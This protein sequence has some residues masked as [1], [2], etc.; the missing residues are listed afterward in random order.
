MAQKQRINQV[1]SGI[2]LLMIGVLAL[3]FTLFLALTPPQGGTAVSP[4]L[5]KYHYYSL[6]LES[7]IANAL[8]WLLVPIPALISLKGGIWRLRRALEIRQ[9]TLEYKAN[10]IWSKIAILIQFKDIIDNGLFLL[11][12][13]ALLTISLH[14]FWYAPKAFTINCFCYMA[15]LIIYFLTRKKL[16]G[17]WSSL[18]RKIEKGMP[19]YTLTEDGVT[20]KLVTM[21][22]KK[23]PDPSPVHIKYNEIDDLQVFTYLEADS[24][25]KYN[26][27]ADLNLGVQQTKDFAQYVKGEIS[28]PSVYAFGG[29]GGSNGN[30]VLIRG[31]QLFYM[32]TFDNDDG[33]NLVQAYRSYKESTK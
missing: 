13:L 7:P 17:L 3:V 25:L 14:E 30:R 22:N 6:T 27:G 12:F 2:G 15:T 26:I 21:W 29:A 32:L 18:N 11:L 5:G 31:P 19:S 9:S 4:W 8:L 20:I 28:R 24:V 23:H 16:E 33:S 10:T 1:M